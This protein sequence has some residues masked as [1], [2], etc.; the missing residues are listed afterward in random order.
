MP[1][2]GPVACSPRASSELGIDEYGSLMGPPHSPRLSHPIE[3]PSVGRDRIRK[4]FDAFVQEPL[5]TA[6]SGPLHSGKRAPRSVHT[7]QA[8]RHPPSR[9][10]LCPVPA[11]LM[12]GAE[13]E[14]KHERA[15]QPA[16]A[17]HGTPP[18]PLPSLHAAVLVARIMKDVRYCHRSAAPHLPPYDHVQAGQASFSGELLAASS[19]HGG[20]A[21]ACTAEA[22]TATTQRAL[23]GDSPSER[24]RQVM[25]AVRYCHK[26][27]EPHIPGRMGARPRDERPTKQRRREEWRGAPGS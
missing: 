27:G 9:R 19:D 10:T 5:K 15:P 3:P 21:T 24:V 11:N 4:M 13:S 7:A 20:G 12:P 2:G 16:R 8:G 23:V 18:P 26:R 6:S 14:R 25:Q 1:F 17:E 22:S